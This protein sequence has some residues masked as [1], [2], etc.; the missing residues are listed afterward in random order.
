MAFFPIMIDCNPGVDGAIALLLALASS[1]LDV[2]GITTTARNAAMPIQP[3]ARQSYNLAPRLDMSVFAGR[4]YPTVR[5]LATAEDVY[6]S[7]NLAGSYPTRT[8]SAPQPQ[9]GVNFLIDNK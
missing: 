9:H 1:E 7:G 6:G 5:A 8:H 4:P 3:T 2:L